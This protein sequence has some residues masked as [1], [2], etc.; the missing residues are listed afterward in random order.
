MVDMFDKT[1]C[2]AFPTQGQPVVGAGDHRRGFESEGAQLNG[3]NQ[4]LPAMADASSE[5]LTS[6]DRSR[7]R[8]KKSNREILSEVDAYIAQFG[9][10][11]T[12][13]E[14]REVLD[15]PAFE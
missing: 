12:P 3:P 5:H 2:S 8:S 1:I 9:R 15:L 7:R 11:L 10:D 6:D 4:G 14:E 13:D